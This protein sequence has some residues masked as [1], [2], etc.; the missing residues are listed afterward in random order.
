MQTWYSATRCFTNT[1]SRPRA[2]LVQS[3]SRV[4]AARVSGRG[5][6]RGLEKVLSVA[7]NAALQAAAGETGRGGG[8]GTTPLDTAG[9]YES[10]SAKTKQWMAA[11]GGALSVPG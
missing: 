1:S 2:A 10:D 6:G 5:R 11:G 9:V 3:F 8:T 7:Y 4:A